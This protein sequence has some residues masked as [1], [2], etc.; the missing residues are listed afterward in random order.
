MA[1]TRTLAQIKTAVQRAGQL[2][3]S[4]DITGSV[5]TG[6]IND[7][8]LETR[9][10][11]VEAWEDY[12]TTSTTQA[13]V[14]GTAS[15]TL[16]TDFYKLRKIDLDIGGGK[17]RRLR[18][19]DLTGSNYY[20]SPG[21]DN[22]FIRYRMQGGNLVFAPPPPAAGTITIYYV[23]I[24]TEL[25]LDADVVTFRVPVELKL[26]TKIALR[27]CLERQ[28]LDT[29]MIDREIARLTDRAV[30][31]AD[32]RD[33]AE[34]FSLDPRGGPIEIYDEDEWGFY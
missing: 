14:A 26:A 13:L 17:F 20:A 5:L 7:A 27:D 12:F 31:S 22:R 23:P 11:L 25:A 2:E 9:E 3:N 33:I 8:L 1:F 16:P 34:P 24:I 29:S 28:E 15:Y 6:I 32:N 19:H 10:I 18:S 21:S 30:H 4:T